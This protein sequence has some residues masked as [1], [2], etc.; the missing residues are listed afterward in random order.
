[1]KQPG[2]DHIDRRAFLRR[3]GITGAAAAAFIGAADVIGLVPASAA[4]QRV[5]SRYG[6]IGNQIH[7]PAHGSCGPAAAGS[8]GLVG[9]TVSNSW[10]P[11]GTTETEA[12]TGFDTYV[13]LPL[14]TK[15]ERVYYELGQYPQ[16]LEGEPLHDI[17]AS[18]AKLQVCLKPLI[19]GLTDP[20]TAASEKTNITNTIN[21]LQ[22]AA[23]KFDVVLFTEPNIAGHFKNA[24]QYKHYIELYGPT[25]RV[26]GTGGAVKLI[27]NPA[28]YGDNSAAYYP[29]DAL[30]DVV[31]I[32]YYGT[33]HKNGIALNPTA[34]LANNH[35]PSPIPFGISEWN[36]VANPG[37]TLTETEWNNYTNY[38]ISYM[39]G[40]L[41]SGL[42]NWDIAMYCGVNIKNSPL[43]Q[44]NSSSDFKVPQI[45]AIYNDLS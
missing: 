44:V 1:M 23:V 6:E 15:V 4:T 37:D 38:L 35:L 20:S 36:A 22:G 27:Y 16:N 14:G 32:D 45:Q 41:T 12:I 9:A 26:G 28:A 19:T 30:T 2:D 10:W 40:R 39:S 25:V 21:L 17:K 8:P 24:T 34:E 42:N 31:S 33:D 3:A 11:T 43:N 5:R 7:S 13:G 29:G 18:G